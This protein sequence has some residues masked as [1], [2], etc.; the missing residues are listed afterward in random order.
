MVTT[1]SQ[2]FS[3]IRAKMYEQ[4]ISQYPLARAEDLNAMKKYLN[5][6]EGER[7]LGIGEGNGFFCSTILASIGKTGFYLVSDPSASQLTNLMRRVKA[8]NLEI[9][10]EKAEDLMIEPESFDKVWS[11]GAFHHCSDQTQSMKNIYNSLRKGGKAVICDVFQGS[12][13]AKHF[14]IQIARYCIT[15]HE[16]KFLSEDFARTLCYNAGFEKSKIKI[17]DLP[18]RWI[19]DSEKDLG[20]FVYKLHAMTLLDGNKQTKIRKTLEGCRK[21]L[22]VNKVDGRY[23]LNWDMRAIIAEK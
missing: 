16:V 20:D 7:V 13:L 17:I 3:G 6:Q 5:P 1:N 2:E 11:F 8:K 10:I 9:C 18:Q 15:G 4:A 14:D 12:K 21:I 23:S 22:G 19:F